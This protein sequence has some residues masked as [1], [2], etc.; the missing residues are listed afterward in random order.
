M[1]KRDAP[2]QESGTGLQ[3]L[4]HPLVPARSTSRC[5]SM[6]RVVCVEFHGDGFPF[7]FGQGYVEVGGFGSG[8]AGMGSLHQYYIVSRWQV[9]KGELAVLVGVD[10][11][12]DLSRGLLGRARPQKQRHA[13]KRSLG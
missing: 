12:L 7:G 3:G 2:W 4:L 10:Y 6:R 5:A 13:A 8:G 9:A 11:F 1:V